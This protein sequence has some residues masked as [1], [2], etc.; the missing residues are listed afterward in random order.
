MATLIERQIE[1]WEKRG[2]LDAETARRLRADVGASLAVPRVGPARRFSFF[3]VVAFFAAVS[4]GAA[5]L[6]FMAA[7]W[8]AIP[9]VMRAAGAVA[10]VFAGFVAGALVNGRQGLRMRIVEEACYLVAGA[11]FM[12][13][14][15][16]VGQMYH[17]SGDIRDT[18]LLYAAALGLSGAAV[19]S[20][21][22]VGVAGGW[23]TFWQVDGPDAGN[24]L[25][26]QFIVF[27]VAIGLGIAFSELVKAAWLRRGFQAAG[28]VG[29]LPF[30][31]EALDWVADRYQSVPEGVR[32]V[33]W[34]IVW[35]LS[36]AGMALERWRPATLR[37]VPLMASPRVGAL[38]GTGL[39]AIAFLHGE[40]DGDAGLVVA[41]SMAVL[42]VL[43]VLYA[44]G[45]DNR[46]TRYVCYALFAGEVLV[47]YGETVYSLLGTSGF[48]LV[49]GLVLAAIA[50]AVHRLER[51][52]R[53]RA[54]R[55][56][57][58]GDA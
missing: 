4:I 49:L 29:L 5:I 50:F 6:L 54:G 40:L 30:L 7:N 35:A 55:V 53:S 16:L 19:R 11:A 26:L 21:V 58:A 46:F 52:W 25:S 42:F 38:F 31:G 28:V 37:A 56:R 13:G 8:G 44:H 18:A 22:L 12:A 15:A 27:A 10:V 1:D 36:L 2:V 32:D 39:V 14:V 48:F 17:I 51:R 33:F 20:A 57:E 41:S 23:I 43:V 47:V 34:A 3:Q 24:L 9:R 45:R